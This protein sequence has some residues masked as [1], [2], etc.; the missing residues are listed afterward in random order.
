VHISA[1]SQTP[2]EGRHV[3]VL[4]WKTS[5]QA[6]LVPEQWSAPSHAPPSD[7][8]VQPV[9]ADL[10][11]LSTQVPAPSHVSWFLHCEPATPQFVPAPAGVSVHDDVPLH[12]LMEHSSLLQVIVVPTQTP[13]AVHVSLNV[14]AFPSLQTTTS[15]TSSAPMSGVAERESASKSAVTDARLTPAFSTGD[16]THSPARL[17]CRSV[18]EMKPGFA[19][20]EADARSLPVA[21][22]HAAI[23]AL[24]VPALPSPPVSPSV[25]PETNRSLK[26]DVKLTNVVPPVAIA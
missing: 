3:N 24:S 7:E 14:H 25:A 9:A 4:S 15:A 10:K 5:T 2:A 26:L 6:L 20:M 11:P 23:S 12:V 22:R 16:L 19:E 18:A 8:P 1:G 17:M 13:G 21:V